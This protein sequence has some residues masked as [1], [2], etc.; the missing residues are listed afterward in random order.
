MED[1]C[2]ELFFNEPLGEATVN[3]LSFG[4]KTRVKGRIE[5]VRLPFKPGSILKA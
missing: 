1:L 2:E 3:Y 5:K 4:S